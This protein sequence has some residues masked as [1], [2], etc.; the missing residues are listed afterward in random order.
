MSTEDPQSAMNTNQFITLDDVKAE[1]GFTDTQ[2]DQT[3]LTIVV[4]SNDELK[5]R[6]VAVVDSVEA[7]EGT[8]FFQR[9]R[10]VAMVF[11][12]AEIR[13]KVNQLYQE[14]DTIMQRFLSMVE[15]LQG[16]MRAIAP[17]RSSRQVVTRTVPFEDDY[18]AERHVP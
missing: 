6:V 12:E 16:D 15:T 8:K 1:F 10:D 3:L 4:A 11:A 18:F 14:S 5:K 13:R 2:D 7:I 9:A 17:V